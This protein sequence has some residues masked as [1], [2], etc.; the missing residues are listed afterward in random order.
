MKVCPKCQK[1]YTDPNLNFCLD[2]GS[3]LTQAAGEQMPETVLLNQPRITN[4]PQM[5]VASQAAWNTA[6]PQPS[7]SMQPKKSSKTWLWVLLILGALVVMC[8][9]GGIVGLFY[10][11]SQV[12]QEEANKNAN[13]KSNSGGLLPGNKNSN[14]SANSTNTSTRNDVENLDLSEWVR[15]NS[16]FGTTEF[17]NG[18]LIM[19]SKQKG[20]YYVLAATAEYT[21]EN[22]DTRVTLRN[23]DNADSRLGYG[24]VFH[25]NPTPLQQGYAFLINTKNQ[26]YEVVHHIPGDEKPVVSWT[27]S[28]AIKS[29]ADE[30][31]LEVRD[32]P[33]KIELYINGEMVN[34]IKNV[35]GY[36]GGVVGLYSGDGVKIAFKDLQIRR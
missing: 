27:K 32:G 20:Y 36:K 2:D 10:L 7:Y 18:E 34:S 11:G 31:T 16:Q 6:P 23:M 33:D 25:S 14:T 30:N 19:G 3:V 29:G 28:D 22:A 17:R 8:G 5:P 15:P 1:T 13:S 12:E 4:Q 26:K 9:G 35:Y 24:L 21:T